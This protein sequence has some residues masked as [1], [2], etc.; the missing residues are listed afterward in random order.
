MKISALLLINLSDLLNIFQ[1]NQF[2]KE[3]F[4]EKI[5]VH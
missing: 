4:L 2:H 3:V 5:E 1:K